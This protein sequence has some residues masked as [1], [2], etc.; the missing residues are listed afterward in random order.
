MEY[1]FQNDSVM[2]M[3][4]VTDNQ[5]AGVGRCVTNISMDG[6]YNKIDPI[7]FVS[8]NQESLKVSLLKFVTYGKNPSVSE[9]Q[10]IIKHIENTVKPMFANFEDVMM[11]YVT[12]NSPDTISF[13]LGDE[14]NA[15]DMEYHRPTMNI[16][17]LLGL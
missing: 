2:S 8:L 13:I 9:R 5:I 15:I 6:R 14:S 1:Y 3:S 12:H 17:Q 7:F 10:I 16:E 11:I 4:F